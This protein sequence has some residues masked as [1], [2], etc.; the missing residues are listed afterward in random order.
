MSFEKPPQ[1]KDMEFSIALKKVPWPSV[2][3]L[4]Q[5]LETPDVI[6]VPVVLPFQNLR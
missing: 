3:P 4:P 5:S 2:P 1:N 6:S